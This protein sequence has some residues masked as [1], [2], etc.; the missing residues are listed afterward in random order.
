MGIDKETI[1]GVIMITVWAIAIIGILLYFKWDMDTTLKDNKLALKPCFKYKDVDKEIYRL[2][3]MLNC[4]PYLYTTC[5]CSGHNVNPVRI[6]FKIPVKKINFVMYYFFNNLN[7][8]DWI[9]CVDTADPNLKSKEIRFYLESKRMVSEMK[10]EINA[11]RNNIL[12]IMLE[13]GFKPKE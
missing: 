12:C 3:R 10:Y 4:I 5:S 9:I 1:Q 6:W 7:F 8:K 2:V 13:N 11:L